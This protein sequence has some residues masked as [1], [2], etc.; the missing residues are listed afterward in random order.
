MAFKTGYLLI[1]HRASPGLPEDVARASGYDPELCK[2]GKQ[3]EADTL[4]C[5]HCR[6]VVAKSPTRDKSGMP[7]AHCSKCSF[8]YICDVCAFKMSQPDYNHMP[9]EKYVDITFDLAERGTL[10]SPPKLIFP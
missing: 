3:Y 6:V 8:R 1:D 2:E 9:F 4:T 10:G 7:R 5:T